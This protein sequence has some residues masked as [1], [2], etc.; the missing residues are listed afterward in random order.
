P[1]NGR[2]Y[3][4]PSVVIAGGGRGGD[5]LSADNTFQY[6][7]SNSKPLEEGKT[8]VWQVQKVYPTTSGSELLESD[9]FVFSIPSVGGDDGTGGG[10]TSG[11]T[12][13]YLQILEQIID[14][15]TYNA[16]FSGELEGFF[17][18]GVVTLN[19]TQQLTQDQLTALASQVLAG[20]ISIKSI[21]VE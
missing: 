14:A 6:P 9:I 7:F 17:P 13:I 2:F 11:G 8:Y 19:G 5:L 1:D 20:R 16:L 21:N 10:S 3:P 4:L 12:N 15:D 18:T